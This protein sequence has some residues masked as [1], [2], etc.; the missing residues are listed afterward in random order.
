MKCIETLLKSLDNK[1]IGNHKLIMNANKEMYYY[2]WTCIC[3][4]NH[5]T[6]TITLTNGGY[7]TPSTT[8]AINCYKRSNYINRLISQGYELIEK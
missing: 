6:Y 3:E 2:H 1:K 8:R 5:E 4:I 7:N